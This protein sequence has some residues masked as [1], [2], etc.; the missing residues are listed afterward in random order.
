M[1]NDFFSLNGN[2]LPSVSQISGV[3]QRASASHVPLVHVGA[4]LQQELTSY[5]RTLKENDRKRFYFSL[6]SLRS[7]Y[8]YIYI[9]N[10]VPLI[11]CYKSQAVVIRSG[12]LCDPAARFIF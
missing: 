1:C 3:V 4:V 5:Q 12:L 7:T 6:F 10:A 9:Y 2:F 8:I 11:V